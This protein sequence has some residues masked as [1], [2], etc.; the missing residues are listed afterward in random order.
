MDLDKKIS[1]YLLQKG[2]IVKT[3]VLTA[4][5]AVIFINLFEPFNSRDWISN[6]SDFKY[7]FYSSLLV[8]LGMCVVAIS[9]TILYKKIAKKGKSLTLWQFALW[10]AGEVCSMAAFFVI[11]EKAIITNDPRSL[12]ELY[13]VS[14]R[15]TFLILFIPYSVLWLYFSWVDKNKRLKEIEQSATSTAPDSLQMINFCGDKGDI[16]FSVKLIDLAYIRSADNYIVVYY[17]ENHKDTLSSK[18][19][20]KSMKDVEEELKPRG[21]VRCHRSFMVNKLHIKLLERTSNGLSVKLD[22]PKGESIPITK[23]YVSDINTLFG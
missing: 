15:N 19:I 22:T 18:M 6:I 5:F 11:F 16:K 9:R 1:P 20:R 7:K 4:L 2:N 17:L 23:N 14:L 12:I 21:I 8:I 10:I 3:V 13:S